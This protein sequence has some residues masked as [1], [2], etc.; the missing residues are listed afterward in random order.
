MVPQL[1][2]AGSCQ[3]KNLPKEFRK[4]GIWMIKYFYHP[5]KNNNSN[6]S[7]KISLSH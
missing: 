7:S 4:Y 1:Q 3:T 2:H 6:N 5:D